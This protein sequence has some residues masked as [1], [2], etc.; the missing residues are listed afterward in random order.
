MKNALH[1]IYYVY[2]LL[3]FVTSPS[4]NDVFAQPCTSIPTEAVINGDFNQGNTGFTTSASYILNPA[5]KSTEWNCA[6]SWDGY[7]V[8]NF[9]STNMPCA[10]KVKYFGTQMGPTWNILGIDGSS[11]NVMFLDPPTGTDVKL[12]EQNVTILPN[13]NYF[14]TFWVASVSAPLKSFQLTVNGTKLT[15]TQGPS[16]TFAVQGRTFDGYDAQGYAKYIYGTISTTWQQYVATWT[17]TSATTASISIIQP[18]IATSTQGNDFII[19]KISFING[20]QNVSTKSKP[21][22]ASDTV[23]ICAST[24]NSVNLSASYVEPSGGNSGNN[25]YSWYLNGST[26]PITGQTSLNYNG[27]TVAGSY[28]ICVDDPDNGCPVSATVVVNKSIKPTLGDVVLCSPPTATLTPVVVPTGTF[29]Y[30]WSG[31]GSGTAASCL[32]ATSGAYTVTVTNPNVTGCSGSATSNVTSKIPTAPTNLTYC[33]GGGT[34]TNLVIGDGKKYNWYKD[35]SMG[36]LTTVTNNGTVTASWTPDIGTTGDQIVYIQSNET[37]AFPGNPKIQTTAPTGFGGTTAVID[38]TATQIINL[39]SVD[40]VFK[41][42]PATG[43]ITLNNGTT[44]YSTNV[45]ASSATTM[46][47]PLGWNLNPGTYK[48]NYTGTSL[49][50]FAW[51][52]NPSVTSI[53]GAVSVND[54]TGK[55]N[56]FNLVFEQSAACDPMPVIVKAV[57]CCTKPVITT[58]P[59]AVTKCEGASASFTVAATGANLTYQWQIESAT[60]GT[61]TDLT[62]TGVYT[63]VTTATMSISNVTGLTGKKYQVIVKT[64][65]T[66]PA[67]SSAATLTVNPTPATPTITSNLT[68]STSFAYCAGMTMALTAATTSTGTAIWTWETKQGTSTTSTNTANKTGITSSEAGLYEVTATINSCV[69]AKG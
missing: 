13:Q 29:N 40:L 31:A 60:P 68:P 43:I 37:S 50:E 12:W 45:T 5:S 15:T 9:E 44:T 63:N 56:F 22:F 21:I 65:G 42:S 36:T 57:S 26:T 8:G 69:S 34:P 23:N 58:Q 20:C 16:K 59:A 6:D 38:I 10:T 2:I 32:A 4:M 48:L 1:R 18:G 27:V 49:A 14:F 35:A 62:N 25:T 33:E 47:I 39:K 30:V 24:V 28:R 64:N 61:F 41:A 54:A 17:S 46:T 51:G 7:W 19:D 55:N 11:D 53:A 52:Q 3:L 66:C 67:T